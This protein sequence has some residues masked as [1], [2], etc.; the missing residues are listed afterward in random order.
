MVKSIGL[1]LTLGEGWHINH[2]HY[3]VY[4]R[5]GFYW[6]EIDKTLYFLRFLSSIGLALDLKPIPVE[7]HESGELK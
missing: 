1:Q 6:W 7:R 2:R 5:L 3:P 4:A